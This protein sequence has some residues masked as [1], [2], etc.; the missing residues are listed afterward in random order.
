MTRHRGVNG[1]KGKSLVSGAWQLQL[2]VRCL[3]AGGIVAHATEGVW[4]LACDPFSQ[5]AVARLLALKGRRLE[6][7]LIVIGAQPQVFEPELTTLTEA[8]LRSV[9]ASWPG[10]VTWLLPTRRFPH[11]ITGGRATVALRVPGHEQS[12]ALS[13]A[14]GGPLVSTS[15]NRAGQTA[16]G[17]IYRAAAFASREPAIDYLLPGTTLAQPAGPSE[18]RDLQ[19]QIH[20]TG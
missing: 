15:A 14:F 1:V 20:R 18:I 6:K 9:T 5:S 11:W 13:G 17:N 3:Q 19:G 2:A 7:G 8:Q 16:A 10:A 4:G 12:R